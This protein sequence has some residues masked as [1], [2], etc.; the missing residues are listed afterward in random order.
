[1]IGELLLEAHLDL[2]TELKWQEEKGRE[3]VL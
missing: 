2:D 3:Q 1:M